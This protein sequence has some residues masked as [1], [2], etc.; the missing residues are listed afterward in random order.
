M[1]GFDAISR[2][3]S[4]LRIA[5]GVVRNVYRKHGL[6]AMVHL[7]W[8]ELSFD[9]F[10][11]TSTVIDAGKSYESSNPVLFRRLIAG[12]PDEA[13]SGTFLDCGAGKGRA[14]ILAACHSF[15]NGLG[16][17][18]SPAFCAEAEQNIGMRG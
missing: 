17:E 6:A 18:I 5:A 7:A 13:R 8:H 1:P 12:V 9:F 11:G 3:A 4:R 2:G 14:L 16:V 15:Q 10:H